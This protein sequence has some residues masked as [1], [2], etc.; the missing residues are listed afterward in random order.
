M[1]I[2]KTCRICENEYPLNET[3]WP[4][5]KKNSKDGFRGECRKCARKMSNEYRIQRK[6]RLGKDFKSWREKH[7]EKAKESGGKYYQKNKE[8]LLLEN[9]KRYEKNKDRYLAQ[10]KEY[11]KKNKSERAKRNREW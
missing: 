5:R 9:K 10:I 11:R 7:P 1:I 6:E 8:R 3:F 2:T 4:I